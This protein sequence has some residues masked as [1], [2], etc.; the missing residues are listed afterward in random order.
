MPAIS[1]N[2]SGSKNNKSIFIVVAV[3]LFAVISAG[4]FI[5]LNQSQAPQN[6]AAEPTLNTGTKNTELITPVPS[7]R[8]TMR[9]PIDTGGLNR[10]CEPDGASCRWEVS[11]STSSNAEF[12]TTFNYE[13]R[14]T[15][16]GQVVKS[17]NTTARLIT[18]TP[19]SGHSYSCTVTP[20]NTCSQGTPVTVK[21]SCIPS[22]TPTITP[23]KAVNVTPSPTHTPTPSATPAV[24]ASTTPT[25][26][27][28]PT[29]TPTPTEIIIVS[30]TNT[31]APSAT[32]KAGSTTNTTPTP[33]PAG[34]VGPTIAVLLFASVIILLGLA[35]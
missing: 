2:T 19:L 15:T 1:V 27:L 16:T 32:S 25:G 34:V 31:P 29:K 26:T 24:T 35:F 20:V 9:T 22:I 21:Q 7:A 10:S 14:D 23:T 17:G 13:I 6:R 33:P 28:T 12:E 18:F 5:Y 11:G 3:V 8:P 30:A 4:L